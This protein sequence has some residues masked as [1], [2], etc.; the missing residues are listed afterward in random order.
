MDSSFYGYQPLNNSNDVSSSIEKLT[1]GPL[2]SG[3]DVLESDHTGPINGV[4]ASEVTEGAAGGANVFAQHSLLP[5]ADEALWGI[6][7]ADN[8]IWQTLGLASDNSIILEPGPLGDP[9]KI[10]KAATANGVLAGFGNGDT[11]RF[12][13]DAGAPYRFTVFAKQSQED[14][15][16]YFGI[17]NYNLGGT[18]IDIYEVSDAGSNNGSTSRTWYTGDL[19]SYDEWYLFVGIVNSFSISTDSQLSGL[20]KVSTGE[21]VESFVDF[22]FNMS[23]TEFM[24]SSYLFDLTPFSTEALYSYW[25]SPRV[26]RL[27][28][29]HPTIM[30]LLGSQ[31]SVLNREISLNADGTLNN[32][33][34]GAVTAEGLGA[35]SLELLSTNSTKPVTITGNK[36]SA[37]YETIGSNLISNGDFTNDAGGW[38]LGSDFVWDR[39]GTVKRV[40]GS[41]NSYFSQNIDI[42]SG[43]YYRLRYD[44]IH[45]GGGNHTNQFSDWSGTGSANH[46]SSLYG[47]GSQ[48]LIIQAGHTDTIEFKLYGIGDFRGYFDNVRIEEVADI[49]DAWDTHVFSK[50]GYPAAS[51]TFV[52][53]QSDSYI[54][55]GLNTDPN[56]NT[57]YDSIDYAWDLKPSGGLGIR[58]NGTEVALGGATYLVGDKFTVTYDGINVKYFRNGS[59]VRTVE[60]ALQSNLYFDSSFARPNQS[61]SKVGFGPITDVQSIPK[62]NVGLDQVTNH[63][64][65]RHDLVDAPNAIKNDQIVLN[66]D[67]TMT[68]AAAGSAVTAAGLGAE[69]LDLLSGGSKPITLRANKIVVGD[70]GTGSEA[71]NT[72]VY[73][74]D[75]YPAAH[76]SFVA[77]QNDAYLMVGLNTDPTENTSYDSIDYS[78][79]LRETGGTRFYSGDN[80]LGDGDAYSIGDKFAITYDGTKVQWF[81]NGNLKK[82]VDVTISGNL[83]L[84]SSYKR[85]NKSISKVSFGAVTDVSTLKGDLE[86]SVNGVAA[87]AVSDGALDGAQVQSQQSLLPGGDD[88]EWELGE[89]GDSKNGKWHKYGTGSENQV[90]YEA[91]PFGDTVKVW[92][93]VTNDEGAT[94][95]GISARSHKFPYTSDAIYRFTVFQKASAKSGTMYW[96]CTAYTSAGTGEYDGENVSEFDGTSNSTNK[97]WHSGDMPENDRWYL[98]VGYLNPNGT[99]VNSG[100]GGLYDVV[101][102]ERVVADDD[103]RVNASGVTHWAPRAVHYDEPAGGD[104]VT[105]RWA[106]PRVERMDR[107]HPSIMQLLANDSSVLNNQ[108]SINADGT[109]NNAGSGGVT[110]EGIGAETLELLSTTGTGDSVEIKGNSITVTGPDRK[111]WDTG[112]YSK[113]GYPTASVSFSPAQDDAFIMVGLNDDPDN[114]ANHDDMVYYWYLRGDYSGGDSSDHKATA[115]IND[116]DLGN[117]FVYSPGDVFTVTYDGVTAKW[118]HNGV[119][120]KS[121]AAS[122]T[123]SLYFDSSWYGYQPYNSSNSQSST[124]KKVSFTEIPSLAV[125]PKSSV[126]LDNL[127]NPPSL[128]TPISTADVSPNIGGVGQSQI[129][130]SVIKAGSAVIAGQG[131]NKAGITG[132]AADGSIGTD[133]NSAE[134]DIR[135]FSGSTFANRASAP[136]RVQ[137]NGA[138]RAE[139]GHIGGFTVGGDS[140]V[141]ETA[142]QPLLTIGSNLAAN[143]AQQISLS[144]RAADEFLLYAGIEVPAG[145]VGLKKSDNPPFGV[146]SD[147]KVFMREFELKDANN[148]VILDSDNL[149]GPAINAQITDL[150]KAG[151]DSVTYTD[152][153]PNTGFKL[154]LTKTQNIQIDWR[155]NP[156]FFRVYGLDK[157]DGSGNGYTEDN[158]LKSICPQIKIKLERST[159]GSTWTT[160]QTKTYAGIRQAGSQPSLGS[161]EYWIDAESY[162]SRS[163]GAAW[164]SEI[165]RGY[166]AVDEAGYFNETYTV[167]NQAAGTYYYRINMNTSG[168]KGIQLYSR[169]YEPADA[170]WYVED[171]VLDAGYGSIGATVTNFGGINNPRN[172]TVTTYSAAGTTAGGSYSIDL[173]ASPP[174]VKE[175]KTFEDF[176]ALT[177]GAVYGTIGL[178]GGGYLRTPRIDGFGGSLILE[179]GESATHSTA[180]SSERVYIN[181]ENG[182]EINSHRNDWNYHAGTNT[183]AGWEGRKTCYIN[184]SVGNSSFPGRIGVSG[185]VQIY[186]GDNMVRLSKGGIRGVDGHTVSSVSS[187]PFF[188]VRTVK[189]RNLTTPTQVQNGDLVHNT[190]HYSSGSIWHGANTFWRS[191]DATV[192]YTMYVKNHGTST[193]TKKLSLH[194]VDDNIYAY[195]NGTLTDSQAWMSGRSE[196]VVDLDIVIPGKDNS[197][198]A[199]KVSRVDIIVNDA[200]GGTDALEMYGSIIDY[201]NHPIEYQPFTA[202]TYAPDDTDFDGE[203]VSNS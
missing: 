50:D 22:R 140:L 41:S 17:K 7:N 75:G 51:T 86:G 24:V 110:A 103:L 79:F 158:A 169:A 184:N 42:V 78:W 94:D 10:W 141:S 64:Q 135:I 159:T 139:F 13:I 203:N 179:A 25:A 5:G 12:S 167:N 46:G 68:G 177:G 92:K 73:S 84:D 183:P 93:S 85:N 178:Y 53:D 74:K 44:V 77:D 137:Q 52:C 49:T 125:I 122:S 147:G 11:D 69:S 132:T 67:G 199:W 72:H 31:A 100:K 113:N 128:I 120:K 201:N 59:L 166:G 36:I 37:D 154:I 43:K 191:A 29:P 168:T 162:Q 180:Q 144:S 20:Y 80:N 109:L 3:K 189:A 173:N 106:L 172:F 60:A 61:L 134:T 181:A 131:T 62:A 190:H 129:D 202:G 90:V 200:G 30:Q 57:S 83:H 45:T 170:A 28:R 148:N 161:N 171:E 8:G 32:A 47:S 104:D 185:D 99:S 164:R 138:F 63:T 196:N 26:D 133:A 145:G 97:A 56:T 127:N 15:Q 115:R 192:M 163:H 130:G 101:T 114:Q 175:G 187:A 112:V 149:L 108:I 98:F 33:G 156:G 82:T 48:D 160:V 40:S 2:T 111:S 65:V 136:F 182:L 55:A 194:R 153:N 4:S 71:W 176:L 1:F 186:G 155:V 152:R 54:A 81:H 39:A 118:F 143:P 188:Y 174:T 124:I 87:N 21:R 27:D 38:S 142:S 76:V 6:P 58:E 126:G 95:G 123:D 23:A 150:L 157:D 193:S 9:A 16:L 18:E 121:Q 14:G 165:R 34:G 105:I 146:D 19:P 107:P 151:A 66:A 88:S 91:G 116:Q 198:D 96:Q 89:A 117:A 119:L 35:E 70:D 195:V 197:T 102:G